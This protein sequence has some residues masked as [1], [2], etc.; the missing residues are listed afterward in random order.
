[1]RN[2]WMTLV[3]LLLLTVIAAPMAEGSPYDVTLCPI[4]RGAFF[5]RG[6]ELWLTITKQDG[7]AV[8]KRT[9]KIANPL[10]DRSH[11]ALVKRGNVTVEVHQDKNGGL[12]VHWGTLADDKE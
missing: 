2:R 12:F 5:L 3:V 8:P 11:E 6:A 4:V 10:D 7:K 1:M 9:E